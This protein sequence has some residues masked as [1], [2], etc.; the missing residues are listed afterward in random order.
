MH[1]DINYD[2]E[3]A[4]DIFNATDALLRHL[5]TQLAE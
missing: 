4:L 3:K 5:A 1:V 2:E